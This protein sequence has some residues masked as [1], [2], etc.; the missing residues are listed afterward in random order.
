MGNLS[1]R[2]GRRI[3]L[4][5][6]LAIFSFLIGASGLATGL[7]GLM[8]S[9]FNFAALTLTVGHLYSET[10]PAGLIATAS[11]VVIAVGELF[12]GSLAL[13]VAGQFATRFGIEH[14]LWLPIVVNAAAVLLCLLLKESL[15]RKVVAT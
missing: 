8:V 1:D 14:L 15:P 5:G 10:V 2:L 6:A 12:G 7:M 3:V 9:F 11:G 13:I 4:V